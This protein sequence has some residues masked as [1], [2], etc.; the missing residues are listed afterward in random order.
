MKHTLNTELLT[1]LSDLVAAKTALHFPPERWSDLEFK[2][3]LAAKKFGFDRKEEF[4]QWLLSS[5]LTTGQVDILASFLT[6][7]ETYFWRE[8]QVFTALIAQVLPALVR[9]RENCNKCI[10]IWSAG[11]ATGEEPYSIAIAL[12]KTIPALKEWNITILATDINPRI[13]RKAM[14][15]LYGKWSFRNAPQWLIDGYFCCKKNEMLEILPEIRKMVTFAYLNLAEDNYPSS[16]NNT[17]AMDIIFCRNVLMY[18]AP[19]RARQVGHG[20]YRSLVDGGWLMIGASELSQH[21]FPQFT[22][23]NFPGAIAYRKEIQGHPLQTAFTHEDVFFQKKPY[24]QTEES[25]AGV[26]QL[27]P[28]L[29]SGKDEKTSMPEN[30]PLLWNKYAAVPEEPAQATATVIAGA[31]KETPDAKAISIRALADRG[32]LDEALILCEEVLTSDKLNPGLYFLKASV[33]QELN[34]IEEACVSLQRTLYL[35]RN[36]V[37]AHFALGNIALRQEKAQ[38]AKKHFDNVLALLKKFKPADIL[39]ESGGLTVGRFR[40][41]I[42]AAMETGALA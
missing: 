15:G 41:I 10:R 19:E 28:P 32:N 22:P 11:C 35:D 29:Q 8:P 39:P 17:N 21:L 31:E 23:V 5:P 14:A 40:E 18:F 9:Y 37:L 6:I 16:L 2:T 3:G 24:L 13:L 36:F 42:Q 30:N 27:A 33:L 34:R 38:A 1:Q 25:F 12:H 7:H 26:E 20:L 4:I